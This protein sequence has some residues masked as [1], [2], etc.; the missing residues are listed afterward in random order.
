MRKTTITNIYQAVAAIV[1]VECTP[2]PSKAQLRLQIEAH[3]YLLRIPARAYKTAI[4]LVDKKLRRELMP[5]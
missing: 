4:Q 5:C 3:R 2:L 1:D